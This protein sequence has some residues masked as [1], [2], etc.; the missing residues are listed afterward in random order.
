MKKKNKEYFSYNNIKT[1]YFFFLHSVHNPSSAHVQN[2]TFFSFSLFF[3][4]SRKVL[5]VSFY[6]F[7]EIVLH[8]AQMQNPQHLDHPLRGILMLPA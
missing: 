6:N 8:I 4:F 2:T 1:M 7:F 3:Y 5:L